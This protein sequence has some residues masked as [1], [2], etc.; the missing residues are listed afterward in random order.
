MSNDNYTA[1][2]ESGSETPGGDSYRGGRLI[3]CSCNHH[4]AP[5][6]I[7]P[8]TAKNIRKVIDDLNRARVR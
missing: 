7:S 4:S 6:G 1:R 8:E 2:D 3:V 5:E